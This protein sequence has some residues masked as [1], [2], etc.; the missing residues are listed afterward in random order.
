MYTYIYMCLYIFIIYIYYIDLIYIYVLHT[1]SMKHPL[2]WT[3]KLN[4][5]YLVRRSRSGF[6]QGFAPGR[7]SEVS[8]QRKRQPRASPLGRLLGCPRKLVK[9]SKM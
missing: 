8:S 9:V 7:A 2:I 5:K 4:L 6:P 1:T 3:H